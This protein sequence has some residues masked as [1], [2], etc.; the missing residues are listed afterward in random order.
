MNDLHLMSVRR[1][2]D[3]DLDVISEL[4]R[5][6]SLEL[7]PTGS[8]EPDQIK[9]RI[10]KNIHSDGQAFLFEI[11]NKIIGYSLVSKNND[12]CSIEEFFIIPEERGKYYGNSAVVLLSEITKWK[13]V[14][15][16][17]PVWHAMAGGM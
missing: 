2:M 13:T 1:G 6:L 11:N 17:A 15:V 8:D 3:D 12:P 10:M 4:S 9:K 5:K 7:N 16:D 14:K